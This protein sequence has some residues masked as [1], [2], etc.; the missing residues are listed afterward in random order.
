MSEL[1]KY[2]LG[3]LAVSVL[4]GCSVND[5]KDEDSVFYLILVAEID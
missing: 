5:V 2:Y 1:Y 3:V 4:A